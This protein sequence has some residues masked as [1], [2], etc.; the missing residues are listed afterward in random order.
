MAKESARDKI[1]SVL[2]KLEV[3]LSKTFVMPQ[4]DKF[5]EGFQKGKRAGLEFAKEALK[6]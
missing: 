2:H 5:E 3:A 1:T 4:A 6:A